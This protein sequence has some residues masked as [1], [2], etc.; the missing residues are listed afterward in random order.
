MLLFSKL[1]IDYM[2]DIVVLSSSYTKVIFYLAI[3]TLELDCSR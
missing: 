2:T 1:E 3:D